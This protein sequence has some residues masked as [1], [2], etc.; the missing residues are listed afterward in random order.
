MNKKYI[1]FTDV[2]GTLYN[3][4]QNKISDSS[5]QALKQA[6]ENGHKIFFCTGRPY[7][8]INPSYFD[9]PIDGCII[10][11]G[12][13]IMMNNQTIYSN[14]IPYE[15]LK[16]LLDYLIQH[17]I[18]FSLDGI[19]R[20]YLF[21]EAHEVFRHFECRN[22]NLPYTTDEYAD[23]LLAENHM[24]PYDLCKEEDLKQICKI[25][26]YTNNTKD[27]IPFLEQ[28]PASMHGYAEK[29]YSVQSFA[30]ITMKENTKSSG[31]DYI[32]NELDYSIEDTIAIGDGFNDIDMI[33]HVSIGIAMGNA[34][35]ELKACADYVTDDIDDDGFAH[36]LNK[37]Q[38]I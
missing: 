36:A 6:R 20:N 38:L 8:D 35:D 10:S 24:Y 21:S 4:K 32:L 5:I 22:Y 7:P 29:A 14:P 12:A 18:G 31:I 13:H 11:C 3:P 15:L 9:L 30:E 19:D 26:I 25:S 23:Q 28:L 16:S 27:L 17:D 1:L 37:F 2:D 33:Q 34:C